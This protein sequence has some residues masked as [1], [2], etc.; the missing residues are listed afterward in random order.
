MV[1][2]MVIALTVQVFPQ[3]PKAVQ[4]SKSYLETYA[5]S[6]HITPK[7]LISIKN[8]KLLMKNSSTHHRFHVCISQQ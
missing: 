7:G 8:N 3:C 1:M 5:H 4:Y 6:L 2:V